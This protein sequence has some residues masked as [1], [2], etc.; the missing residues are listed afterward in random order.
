MI[1]IY[2]GD[3]KGKTTAAAGLALRAVGNQIPVLFAA[4]MKDGSSGEMAVLESLPQVRILH[5]AVFY[6]FTKYMSPQQK[7][8]MKQQ[9][10][11]MLSRV[12][13]EICAVKDSSMLV[14]L[15]EV[16]HACNKELL[17]EEALCRVLDSCPANVEVVLTGRKPSPA[18][19]KRADYISEVRKIRHPYDRGIPA[20]KG[21]EL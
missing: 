6:G 14:V 16:I 19:L 1:H 17:S 9:Y 2:C 3:G 13:T 15:D 4:F 21:I 11:S 20:R 12:K 8:E 7:E 10:A 18:L 5:A